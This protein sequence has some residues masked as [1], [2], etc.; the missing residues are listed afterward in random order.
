MNVE[1]DDWAVVRVEGAD[2]AHPI[3]VV[4]DDTAIAAAGDDHR[5]LAR[6]AQA[7]D[8]AVVAVEGAGVGDVDLV[9]LHAEEKR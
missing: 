7:R 1:G 4:D 8:F 9:L 3:G 2:E 6:G 5:E